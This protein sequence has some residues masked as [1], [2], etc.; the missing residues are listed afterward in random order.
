MACSTVI[1]ASGLKF[2]SRLG[3]PQ[4]IHRSTLGYLRVIA[5]AK[6][7]KSS[8]SS[9]IQFQGRPPLAHLGAPISISCTFIPCCCASL[10]ESVRYPGHSYAGSLGSVG[11]AGLRSGAIISQRAWMAKMPTPR[12][13]MVGKV[14]LPSGRND[15]P[16]ISFLVVCGA[17]PEALASSSE[18][19]SSRAA[20]AA[21]AITTTIPSAAAATV[22][23][24]NRLPPAAELSVF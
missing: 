5:V 2:G 17:G 23:G 20:K 3:S 7:P 21:A 18:S 13:R 16:H 19:V 9:G 8:G 4:I 15:S 6:S 12:S 1:G 22:S 10:I 14:E 11:S 24:R